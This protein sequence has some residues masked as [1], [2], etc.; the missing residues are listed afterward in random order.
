MRADL[1]SMTEFHRSGQAPQWRHFF[2]QWNAQV[3]AG[4]RQVQ[5]FAPQPISVVRIVE[6]K[7]KE[8]LQQ[9]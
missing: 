6:F 4:N 1:E 5:A 2:A 7:T 3:A 9:Q 8:I